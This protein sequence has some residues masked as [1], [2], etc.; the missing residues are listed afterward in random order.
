[1][2]RRPPRSTLFPYTTLFRSEALAEKAFVR[3]Q[4]IDVVLGNR[5][6]DVDHFLLQ[7]DELLDQHV[8]RCAP[9]GKRPRARVSLWKPYVGVAT[10]S[11]TTTTAANV[12]V[13]ASA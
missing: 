8:E 4:A 12:A 3:E 6:G 11:T 10:A 5:V 7:Q 1:M 13:A 9:V 2:I